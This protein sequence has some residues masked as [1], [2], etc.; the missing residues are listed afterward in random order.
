MSSGTSAPWS[1]AL[2]PKPQEEPVLSTYPPPLLPCG[3][4]ARPLAIPSCCLGLSA[5]GRTDNMHSMC[6]PAV[7]FG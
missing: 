3:R 2:T 4:G 1:E 5:C 6:Q 7:G